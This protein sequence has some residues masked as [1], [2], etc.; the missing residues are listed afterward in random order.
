MKASSIYMFLLAIVLIFGL[1]FVAGKNQEQKFRDG[2]GNI[3]PGFA[4]DL[5]VK[6][7]FVELDSIDYLKLNKFFPQS[8]YKP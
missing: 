7:Q 3:L 4:V 5:L 6:D 2:E 8:Y 1:G